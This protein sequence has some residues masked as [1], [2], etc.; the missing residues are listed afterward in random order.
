MRRRNGYIFCASV[1]KMK[2]S[3]IQK[4]LIRN[5]ITRHRMILCCT[6]SSYV[7]HCHLKM[8]IFKTIMTFETNI[9][10]FFLIF[11]VYSGNTA[12]FPSFSLV[13]SE[14]MCVSLIK[15]VSFHPPMVEFYISVQRLNH[16]LNR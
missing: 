11:P 10:T 3:C 12:V 2:H 1:L 13:H 6:Q 16:E 4:Q 9:A 8:I 7:K 5:D 14:M 15:Q